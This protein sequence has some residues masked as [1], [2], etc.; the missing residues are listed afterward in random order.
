MRVNSNKVVTKLNA[1]KLDGQEA[2]SLLPGGDLPSGRTVRGTYDIRG[3]V[4]SVSGGG[5]GYDSSAISFGYRLASAPNVQFVKVGEASTT[6]CPGTAASP[7]AVPGYLCI[8]E[9]SYDNLYNHTNYP[10]N[11]FVTRDGANVI[12]YSGNIRVANQS[13]SF[14]T[15]GTW[16]V[17]GN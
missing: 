16:A 2:A 13:D 3:T 6:E 7:E 14:Y 10:N 11:D 8:Y 5:L 4:P 9:S 17:T 12:A 1:D 15:K